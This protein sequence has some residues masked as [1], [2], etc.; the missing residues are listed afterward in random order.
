MQ[1]HKFK[2][3]HFYVIHTSRAI[4]IL[5]ITIEYYALLNGTEYKYY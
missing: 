4:L 3:Y 5:I 2:S 1:K